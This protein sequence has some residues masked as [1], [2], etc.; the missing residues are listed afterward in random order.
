MQ[1]KCGPGVVSF[2]QFV[3]KASGLLLT[4]LDVV[5]AASPLPAAVC[6]WLFSYLA[7][8]TSG[9][10]ALAALMAELVCNGG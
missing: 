4:K 3:Y 9:Y 1:I 8:L 6:F 2:L 5:T 7:T 10:F